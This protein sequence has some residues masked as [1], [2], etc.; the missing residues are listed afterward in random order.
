MVRTAPAS[1]R[2]AIAVHAV[3]RALPSDLMRSDSLGSD[4]APSVSSPEPIRCNNHAAITGAAA[5]AV[6][7]TVRHVRD[8]HRQQDDSAQLTHIFADHWTCTAGP[9]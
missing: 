9:I 5:S 6:Y 2:Q 4:R 8:H 3:V 7:K 1:R